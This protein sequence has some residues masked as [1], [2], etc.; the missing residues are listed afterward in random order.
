[1]YK[2]QILTVNLDGGWRSLAQVP[3]GVPVSLKY[4]T[5]TCLVGLPSPIH[6]AALVSEKPSKES[7]RQQLCLSRMEELGFTSTFRL[8]YTDIH[9]L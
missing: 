8:N 5:F 1:M 6:N 7:P 4:V 3:P 9:P 2:H